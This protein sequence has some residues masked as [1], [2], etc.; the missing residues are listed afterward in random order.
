MHT[1]DIH[2]HIK[3]LLWERIIYID[4]RRSERTR[5]PDRRLHG[6]ALLQQHLDECGG[7]VSA[8]AGHARRIPHR[9]LVA[10]RPVIARQTMINDAASPNDKGKGL[11]PKFKLRDSPGCRDP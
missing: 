11:R 2:T 10:H 3:G 4:G 9:L 1:M 6:V 5:V 7:D 8:P